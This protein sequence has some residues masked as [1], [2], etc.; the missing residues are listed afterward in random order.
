MEYLTFFWKSF[1]VVGILVAILLLGFTAYG[2]LLPKN[3]RQDLYNNRGQIIS[4]L[5]LIATP[6]VLYEFIQINVVPHTIFLVLTGFIFKDQI[7]DFVYGAKFK[8]NKNVKVGDTF[9]VDD[10]ELG[11][12]LK[13]NMFSLVLNDANRTTIL[14]YGS[15]RNKV[16]QIGHKQNNVRYVNFDIHGDRTIDQ[17]ES[18]LYRSPYADT[19]T[20]PRIER[21]DASTINIKCSLLEHGSASSLKKYLESH[22]LTNKA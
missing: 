22:T 15:L 20:K 4:L 2:M 6:I 19:A 13:L 17:I 12:I 14:Q 21:V 5:I 16:I 11:V 7:I 1:L 8:L 9:I 18:L 3:K 10:K